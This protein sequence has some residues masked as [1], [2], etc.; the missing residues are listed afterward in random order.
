MKRRTRRAKS[1]MLLDQ[2]GAGAPKRLKGRILKKKNGRSSVEGERS[3]GEVFLA[4]SSPL[5]FIRAERD[6]FEAG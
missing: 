1:A 5:R 3:S 2:V 6:G 4:V